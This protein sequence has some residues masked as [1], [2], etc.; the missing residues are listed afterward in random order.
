MSRWDSLP[1]TRRLDLVDALGVNVASLDASVLH[2]LDA[3]R[4]SKDGWEVRPALVE[5]APL[6]EAVLAKLYPVLAGHEVSCRL[7]AAHVWADPVALGRVLELLLVNACRFSPPASSVG[8]RVTGS[9]SDGWELSVAD[10]GQGISPADLPRIF[11]RL[12]RADVQDTGVSRA[13]AWPSSR[14]WPS[15]TGGPPPPRRGSTFHQP[16]APSPSV[17]AEGRPAT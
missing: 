2:I 14:S 9:A 15:A 10:Q 6:V 5:V 8:V 13:W 4:L 12:W 17:Q 11:D 7:D 3:S 1:E 16:P